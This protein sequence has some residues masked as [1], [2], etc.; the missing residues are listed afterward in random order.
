MLFL[1]PNQQCQ[2][3]KGKHCV[4]EI[5]IKIKYNNNNDNK[6]A[7]SNLAREP[8][9]Y[10]SLPLGRFDIDGKSGRQKTESLVWGTAYK[11]PAV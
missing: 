2:S 1:P 6:S 11:R 4:T 3:A 8:C 7:Q 9:H 10:K 5:K